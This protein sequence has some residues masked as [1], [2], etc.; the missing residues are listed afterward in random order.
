MN[1]ADLLILAN[2]AQQG[3][4]SATS[5]DVNTHTTGIDAELML[6]LEAIAAG[7]RVYLTPVEIDG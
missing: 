1:S 3:G 4:H 7:I 5:S 6:I 2:A